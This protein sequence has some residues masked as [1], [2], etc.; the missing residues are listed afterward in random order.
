VDH[1]VGWIERR[2]DRGRTALTT[3][4]PGGFA[5]CVRILHPFHDRAGDPV[6]WATAAEMPDA[7]AVDEAWPTEVER[8]LGKGAE[9]R[10]TRSGYDDIGGGGAEILVEDPG[11]MR[12]RR[13]AWVPLPPRRRRSRRR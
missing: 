9:S 7:D 8:A 6:R 13:R 4:V 2:L 12:R 11:R 10:L 1:P 5:S 3:F